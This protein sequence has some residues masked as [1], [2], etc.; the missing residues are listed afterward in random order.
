MSMDKMRIITAV[1]V[2]E[3]GRLWLRWSDGVEARLDMSG[4]VSSKGSM[5]TASVGEWGHSVVWPNGVELGADRLWLETLSANGHDDSRQFL[6]P[7][8][9]SANKPARQISL[10]GKSALTTTFFAGK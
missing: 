6:E 5:G 2:Q 9:P 4:L 3:A 1:E 10:F 8:V 7:S